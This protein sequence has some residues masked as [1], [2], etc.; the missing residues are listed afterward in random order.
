MFPAAIII[1]RYIQTHD[2][3]QGM[4]VHPGWN[5]VVPCQGDVYAIYQVLEGHSSDLTINYSSSKTGSIR[6]LKDIMATPSIL[7][8]PMLI[9]AHA[10]LVNVAH[11]KRD[12]G[13][14][15]FQAALARMGKHS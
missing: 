4:L 13:D 5:E 7:H 2:D 9:E 12:H 15:Y 8:K 3:V 10:R 11:F 1:Y 14:L 6:S